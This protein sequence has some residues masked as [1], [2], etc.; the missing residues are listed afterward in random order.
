MVQFWGPASAVAIADGVGT[1]SFTECH[2]DNWDNHLNATGTGTPFQRSYSRDISNG[3]ILQFPFDVQFLCFFDKNVVRLRTSRQRGSRAAGVWTHAILPS[4]ADSRSS[5]TGCFCSQRHPDPLR[6]RVQTEGHAA[7]DC[8]CHQD[9]DDRRREHHQG[10]PDDRQQGRPE[11]E[12][13]RGERKATSNLPLLV[14]YG[15]T[16]TD[17]L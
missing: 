1:V 4:L 2:F 16:L 13:H 8:R 15:Y 11:G 10:T 7:L 17:C 3:V 6:Q 9:E 14:I 12:G 5:L